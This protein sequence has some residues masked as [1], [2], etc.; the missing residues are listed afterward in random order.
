LI[1]VSVVHEYMRARSLGEQ[2]LM[3]P[4]DLIKRG[5]SQI[6]SYFGSGFLTGLLVGV[7]ALLCIIPGVYAYTVLCLAL[8]CHAMERSG[9]AGS[10][11]RSNQLVQGDFWPTLGLA[12]V[13]G[14]INGVANLIVQIPF[15][16]IGVVIGVNSGLE[17]VETGGDMG[18][19]E[20]FGIYNSIATAVQWCFQM[21]TY[22]IV[23]VCM[24]LKY[25]SRVEEKEGHG[26]KE[27]IAGFEQM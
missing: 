2:E 20:W 24:C 19:P 16:I 4:G 17:M 9:G 12:I 11:G 3:T 25:F 27:R 22:P 15:M 7:G 13:I 18:Y 8:A 1:V 6:G 23:A 10:L 14:M 21:L 26:L 5:F